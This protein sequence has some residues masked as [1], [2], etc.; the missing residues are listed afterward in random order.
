MLIAVSILAIAVT[1]LMQVFSNNLRSLSY[2]EDHINA[3]IRAEE[4]IR[5]L[6]ISSEIAE[7]SYLSRTPEGFIIKSDVIAVN[8]E[9]TKDIP[10]SMFEVTVTVL[11][12]KDKGE[13]SITLKTYKTIAKK[14]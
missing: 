6:S 5:D 13:R 8:S 1:V 9:R 10:V 7:G 4:A 11:W 3:L 14:V 12:Q 2:S